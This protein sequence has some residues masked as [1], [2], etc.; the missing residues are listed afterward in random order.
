MNFKESKPIYMQIVDSIMDS[1]QSGEYPEESRMPSVREF[2][3]RF[4]VNPNTM[5]RAYD[6]LQQQGMIYNKRG[7]GF[8]VTQG[9]RDRVIKER[10]KEFFDNEM[11]YFLQRLESFGVSPDELAQRYAEF[12]KKSASSK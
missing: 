9:C 5:M 1:V 6:W 10:V 3:S 12:L 4:E 11:A 8:F 7:I 2:A